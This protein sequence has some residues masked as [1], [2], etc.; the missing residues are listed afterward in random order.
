MAINLSIQYNDGR[1]PDII[2]LLTYMVTTIGE[3]VVMPFRGFVFALW[4]Q[5][6]I[7]TLFD[8]VWYGHTYNH[9]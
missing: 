5:Y 4:K 2:I 8:D 9:T 7:T 1:L 6:F 3:H